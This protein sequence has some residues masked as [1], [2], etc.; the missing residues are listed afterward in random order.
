MAYH[1]MVYLLI[2]SPIAAWA[3][4]SQDERVRRVFFLVG[5]VVF[6][7][8]LIFLVDW[9]GKRVDRFLSDLFQS[10]DNANLPLACRGSLDEALAGLRRIQLSRVA[11]FQAGVGR[12]LLLRGWIGSELSQ[13]NPT[14]VRLVAKGGVRSF[15]GFTTIQLPRPD[16]VIATAIPMLEKSG[17]QAEAVLPS[18][19]PPGEYSV[20]VECRDAARTDQ[21]LSS[22][23]VE[24][25]SAEIG[26][27]ID[28]PLERELSEQKRNAS[29]ADTTLVPTITPSKK[30]Q[31]SKKAK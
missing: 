4:L 8:L 12:K 17:F 23:V 3:I 26:A 29:L 11:S 7:F 31:P 25:V 13:N 2:T 19:L 14:T 15:E 9:Q 24:V 5:Y 22:I 30:S 10:T 16:V 18:D 21:F 1:L 20:V 28:A 6:S 27:A